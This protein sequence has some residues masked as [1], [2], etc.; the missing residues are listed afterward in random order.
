MGEETRKKAGI[1]M[2]AVPKLYVMKKNAFYSTIILSTKVLSP[3]KNSDGSFT[4]GVP[5]LQLAKNATTI[6]TKIN[7]LILLWFGLR[8]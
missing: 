6:K 3:F 7:F 1:E 4:G 8:V 5:L 2:P